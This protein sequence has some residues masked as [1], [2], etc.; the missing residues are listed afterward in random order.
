ME[1]DDMRSRDAKYEERTQTNYNQRNVTKP[2][3]D[4]SPGDNV[5]I[6]TDSHKS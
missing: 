3:S 1:R 2:L 5:R 4:L 6:K